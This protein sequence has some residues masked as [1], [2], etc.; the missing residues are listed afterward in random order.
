[1]GGQIRSVVR[2]GCRL[3]LTAL[4]PALVR[5][6]VFGRE[7]VPTNG[8]LV[9]VSNHI[10]HLDAPLQVAL[11]PWPI[12]FIALTDLWQVPV[13]GWL[14]RLYGAIP[15]RRGEGD[16]EALRAAM[17]VLSR[18]GVLGIAPEGRIA[19]GSALERPQPGAAYLALRGGAPLLPVGIAGAER[20]LENIKRRQR[21]DV[22]VRIGA[23]FVLSPAEGSR[24]ERLARASDE[25]MEHIAAL[26]PV[27][28]Q[29]VYVQTERDG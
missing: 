29:G 11:L 14:I 7:H 5:L 25:I 13:T 12:E 9:V 21:T 17:D 1:M 26:L 27:A 20:V 8:P 10:S 28:Y 2:R 22:T 18:G 23:P 19:P 24:R 16:R 6:R 15:L 3:F 4:L